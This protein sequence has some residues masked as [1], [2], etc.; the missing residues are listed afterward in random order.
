[1]PYLIGLTD[2]DIKQPEKLCLGTGCGRE[3]AELE[4]YEKNN[5]RIAPAVL[6]RHRISDLLDKYPISQSGGI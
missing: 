3:E 6:L 4:S 5:I 2:A 1:M